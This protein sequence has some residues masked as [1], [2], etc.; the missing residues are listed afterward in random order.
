VVPKEDAK[1]KGIG[2][3]G[4]LTRLQRLWRH[5]LDV[6]AFVSHHSSL[7]LSLYVVNKSGGAY[8]EGTEVL[9]CCGHL[10]VGFVRSSQPKVRYVHLY[11]F[12]WVR[13]L[14]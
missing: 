3:F 13:A 6:I 12:V 1:R 14:D 10:A 2:G 9:L 11:S 8:S 5:P 7:S 4:V